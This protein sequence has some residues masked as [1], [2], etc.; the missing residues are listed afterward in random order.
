MA[1]RIGTQETVRVFLGDRPVIRLMYN[2]FQVWPAG[3]P[4]FGKSII[5][6]AYRDAEPMPYDLAAINILT[7][8]G[9]TVTAIHHTEILGMDYKSVGWLI[10]GAPG[11]RDEA[12]FGQDYIDALEVNVM[13]LCRNTAINVLG[14]ASDGM[15]I[16]AN[17]FRVENVKHAIRLRDYYLGQ[18]V[19]IGTAVVNQEISN[20]TPGHTLILSNDHSPAAAGVVARDTGEF[21]R[22]FWGYYRFD[23]IQVAG[24]DLFREIMV[25]IYKLRSPEIMGVSWTGAM[26]DSEL[27]LLSPVI[28]NVLK[29]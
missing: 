29:E 8:Y 18:K 25:M 21:R 6:F 28:K 11:D 16:G 14:M 24:V 5:L 9:F 19:T 3:H 12:V 10:I 27:P 7:E 17:T 22:V 2:E 23:E 4:E 1:L 26:D 15:A 20:L 13:T